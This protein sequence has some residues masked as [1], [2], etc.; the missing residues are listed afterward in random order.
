MRLSLLTASAGAALGLAL[1]A[2][3]VDA[4]TS[5][6]A[7]NDPTNIK[8]NGQTAVCG[9]TL[10]DGAV[11][12]YMGIQ[13]ASQARWQNPTPIAW[14]PA[15]ATAQTTAGP[16]CV[17]DTPGWQTNPPKQNED[18]LYLNVWAPSGTINKPKSLPVMVFIHGGAF[19][20]GAGSSP[21]YDGTSFAQNGVVIV[22]LNYRL[23]ALGFLAASGIPTSATDKTGV[24]VA[25]N[26]GLLDQ[27][28][29]MNWVKNNIGAFGGDP[30]RITLFGESAG[31][32]SVGLHTFTMPSSA[33]LFQAAIM[34]SNP[35]A[36]QYRKPA[37][38]TSEGNDFIN[39]VCTVKGQNPCKLTWAQLQDTTYLSPSEILIA[40]DAVAKKFSSSLNVIGSFSL[41]WSPYLDGSLVKGQPYAGYVNGTTPV[42]I[43]FGVNQNEGTVFAALAYNQ[44]SSYFT[45]DLYK[46]FL[47]WKFGPIHAA[48]I[49]LKSKYQVQTQPQVSY[50]NQTAFAL[51]SVM[52]DYGFACGNIAAAN[53]AG[54][55]KPVY[56]YLF[57]QQTPFDLYITGDT[58]PGTPLPACSTSAAPGTNVCHADELPYVFNTIL[59]VAPNAGQPD[60]KL[61]ASMNA[62][63]AAFAKNPAA[64][65]TG[66]TAYTPFDPKKKTGGSV[67]VWNSSTSGTS[68]LATNANCQ[69]FL[70]TSPYKSAS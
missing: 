54:T 64:P 12:G 20:E 59:S 40:Q 9:N 28:A 56:G 5:T 22:T 66:W 7:A 46:G 60:I 26:F 36:N 6:C 53:N 49:L 35:L 29:A 27:Q 25:G 16:I 38:A 19:I 57:S 18:C 24:N 30:G 65:G 41:P 3:P 61:A 34:E 44:F 62:A 15:T 31:A 69:L 43:G 67:G 23:G 51:A 21:L 39:A 14:P 58:P 48:E 10:A 8:V 2:A 11:Y 45:P 4:Q 52:T 68:P 32:M 70:D 47:T 13:Y 37:D 17:Q 50:M 1:L 42:P 55:S 63:W 33:G